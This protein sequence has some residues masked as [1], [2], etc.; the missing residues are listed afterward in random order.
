MTSATDL[1][2]LISRLEAAREGSREL[3]AEIWKA[4]GL[5]P[6]QEKHCAE[7]CRMDGRTDL[8]RERYIAAWAPNFTTSIDAAMTLLPERTQWQ[9][10]RT[11]IF[12]QEDSCR[13]E[14]DWSNGTWADTPPLALCIAALKA[15]AAA[16]GGGK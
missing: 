10:N 2:S 16:S 1:S 14:V 15:R 4:I 9:L 12:D 8:T 13:A 7:W 11:G 3:D 6:K 5:T